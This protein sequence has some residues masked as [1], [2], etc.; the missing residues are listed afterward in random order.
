MSVVVW[1]INE[2][3]NRRELW[4]E[5]SPRSEG[6]RP[7]QGRSQFR[8]K[9]INILHP[10]HRTARDIYSLTHAHTHM[11]TRVSLSMLKCVKVISNSHLVEHLNGLTSHWTIALTVSPNKHRCK[12]NK[13]LHSQTQNLRS[14]QSRRMVLVKYSKHLFEQVQSWTFRATRSS[15]YLFS[16][17][18]IFSLKSGVNTWTC[19]IVAPKH[20]LLY[21]HS[22][23]HWGYFSRNIQWVL[24]GLLEVL[25]LF[26]VGAI[27]L[28]NVFWIT[29]SYNHAKAQLHICWTNQTV[30]LLA[31][32]HQLWQLSKVNSRRT[33]K[34]LF[35]HS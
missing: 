34:N 20:P 15:D 17:W 7:F 29:L 13:K 1:I 5:R 24:P 35:P 19:R 14:W 9:S 31:K 8:T 32:V 6:P 23:S 26:A 22:I 18:L 16:L 10:S 12:K 27:C 28:K 25:H 11:H 33:S 4:Q 3:K 30:A 21:T 2:H